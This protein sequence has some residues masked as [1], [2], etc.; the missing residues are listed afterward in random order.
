[1]IPVTHPRL[2][3]FWK[4]AAVPSTLCYILI[5]C[6]PK[7]PEGRLLFTPPAETS[8]SIDFPSTAFPVSKTNAKIFKPIRPRLLLLPQTAA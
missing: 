7:I 8:Q 5:V 3:S 4:I 2:S 6:R 1:M